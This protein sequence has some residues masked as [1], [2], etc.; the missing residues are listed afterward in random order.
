MKTIRK[1]LSK[2]G[3]EPIYRPRK[4]VE[5]DVYSYIPSVAVLSAGKLLDSRLSHTGDETNPSVQLAYDPIA[6]ASSARA[7]LKNR[8][9]FVEKATSS[10][11][12]KKVASAPAES[13]SSE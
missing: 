8:S 2:F 13:G 9:A 5:T 12:S 10:A 11:K 7:Y 6:L 4:Q 1:K 3:K